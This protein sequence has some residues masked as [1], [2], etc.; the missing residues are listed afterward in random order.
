VVTVG[1]KEAARPRWGQADLFP[2][3][4]AQTT[5]RTTSHHIAWCQQRSGTWKGEE[6]RELLAIW[7]LWDTEGRTSQ[8]LTKWLWGLPSFR[9]A[10]SLRQ[11]FYP[12]SRVNHLFFLGHWFDHARWHRRLPS[13]SKYT[14]L[15]SMACWTSSREAR[16]HSSGAANHYR[17][18][19]D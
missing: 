16:S 12:S 7:L 5:R 18:R 9:P 8:C 2:C 15:L 14:Y 19:H 13:I 17:P 4:S 6:I 10:V 11:N 3:R 1:E